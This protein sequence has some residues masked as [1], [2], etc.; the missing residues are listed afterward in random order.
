[1]ARKKTRPTIFDEYGVWSD[2][3]RKVV[4]EIDKAIVPIILKHVK[5]LGPREA[6]YLSPLFFQQANYQIVVIAS[7]A[8]M[9]AEEKMKRKARGR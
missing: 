8:R 3:G 6:R 7:R 2:Y 9:E 4:K 1:M 5:K